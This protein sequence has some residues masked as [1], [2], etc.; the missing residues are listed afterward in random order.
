MASELNSALLAASKNDTG[1]TTRS[2]LASLAMR[3]TGS[4]FSSGCAHA[5]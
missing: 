3:W 5:M 2:S 4:L 1:S